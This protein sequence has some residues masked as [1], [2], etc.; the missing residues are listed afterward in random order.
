M[1]TAK[2]TA[3][4]ILFGVV[5][6]PTMFMACSDDPFGGEKHEYSEN[7]LSIIPYVDCGNSE[8]AEAITRASGIDYGDTSEDNLSDE[9]KEGDDDLNENTLEF[10][11]VYVEDVTN[12]H[13]DSHT[14]LK[15]YKVPNSFGTSV[16]KDQDNQ[17][18]VNWKSEGLRNDG[19]YNIYVTANNT[20]FNSDDITTVAQLKAHVTTDANIF[21][22]Y[23]V[24]DQYYNDPDN[25]TIGGLKSY[26]FG[27]DPDKKFHMTG[28]LKE[29]T[30]DRKSVV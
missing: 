20:A 19:K 24:D 15:H 1:N 5:I 16:L 27:Y 13:S 4:K 9:N 11:D 25:K 22:S 3:L 8:L 7:M 17:L 14:F 30:P 10:I 21:R 12:G 26:Y 18:A 2:H 29:W 23:N 28:F 6:L